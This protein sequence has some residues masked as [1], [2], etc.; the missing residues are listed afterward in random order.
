[1]GSHFGSL[2]KYIL[3][4]FHTYFLDFEAGTCFRKNT[5]DTPIAV[6]SLFKSCGQTCVT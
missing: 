3:S 5:S 1:M 6:N 4:Y 2:P